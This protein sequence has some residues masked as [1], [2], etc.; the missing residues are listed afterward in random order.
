MFD[1]LSVHNVFGWIEN[2]VNGW[3][4][5]SMHSFLQ[6]VSDLSFNTC[7]IV[8]MVALILYIFGYDKGKKVA[9]LSPAIYLLIK[10]IGNIV[11][12]V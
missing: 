6:L 2:W 4:E 12:G 8:G 9:T 10:I 1:Y 5:Q 11:F 7:L 3:F